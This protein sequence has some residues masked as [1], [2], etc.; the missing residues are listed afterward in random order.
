MGYWFVVMFMKCLRQASHSKNDFTQPLMPLR[1][2]KAATDSLD[3]L[4]APL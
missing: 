4:D 2:A 3:A 1:G